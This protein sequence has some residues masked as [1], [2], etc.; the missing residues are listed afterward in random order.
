MNIQTRSAYDTNGVQILRGVISHAQLLHLRRDLR[1]LLTFAPDPTDKDRLYKVYQAAARSHAFQ[2][3]QHG[4]GSIV[5]G[6]APLLHISG[7][8]LFSAPNDTRLTYDWHQESSYMPGLNNP[9]FNFWFPVMEPATKANG[10][11]SVLA[12][13]HKLGRLTYTKSSK[14]QGY[15]D[16]TPLGDYA[17][18]FPELVCECGLG[19][20]VMFDG[21]L[22]HKS[23]PNTSGRTRYTGVSRFTAVR[24]LPD[25]L[26][27][28]SELY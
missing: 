3:I 21:D 10:A 15:T 9:I 28:F 2:G 11:M 19:D 17:E 6:Q 13:S 4:L 23:N 25:R 22:I 12:G 24:E 16:L 26:E 14:P 20:V 8:V 5:G 27:K 7:A 1:R 18:R